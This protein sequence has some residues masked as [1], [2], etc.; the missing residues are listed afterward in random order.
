M[1]SDI[2]CPEC[3][4]NKLLLKSETDAYCDNC[5]TEFIVID[6]DKMII[7]YK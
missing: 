4:K 3:F 2:L 7:K 6:K 1:K 5:K